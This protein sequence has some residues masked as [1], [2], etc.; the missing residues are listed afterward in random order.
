L[1]GVAHGF[2]FTAIGLR[3]VQW[4]GRLWETRD[5]RKE[6]WRESSVQINHRWAHQASS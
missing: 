2:V 3:R 1:A 4:D 5:L 6:M